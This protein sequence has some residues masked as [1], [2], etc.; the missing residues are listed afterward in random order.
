MMQ[1]KMGNRISG[2]GGPGTGAAGTAK[3]GAA[4]RGAAKSGGPKKSVTAAPIQAMQLLGRWTRV[5]QGHIAYGSSCACCADF[6][7]LQAQDMEQHILDYIDAKYRA[8]GA[9]RVCDL[10]A[11]RA[12]YRHARS[13]SISE[14][15]RSLA[16][17]ADKSVPEAQQLE[18]LADLGRSIESL[19]EA[20][21]NGA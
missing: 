3:G 9:Q 21:R 6:G 18:V 10:L 1:G 20:M 5:A 4:K 2:K 14:L 13:G 17:Q 12:G 11:E 19:D 7:N 16:T 15:L 8:A